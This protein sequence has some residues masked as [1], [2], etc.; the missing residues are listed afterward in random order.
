MTEAK[1]KRRSITA[2]RE[3]KVVGSAVDKYD[4]GEGDTIGDLMLQLER[5][6]LNE[7]ASK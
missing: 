3:W 6:A 7:V 1:P 2:V 5:A 4:L